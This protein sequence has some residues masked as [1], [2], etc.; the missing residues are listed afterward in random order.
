MSPSYSEARVVQLLEL[1]RKFKDKITSRVEQ[2]HRIWREQDKE[3][4]F[5]ELIFCLLTPQSK[6]KYCWAAVEELFRD[7]FIFHANWRQIAEKL[8]Y[9]RFR[10]TKAKRIE[11]VS[12]NFAEKRTCIVFEILHNCNKNKVARDEL[13]KQINGLGYKEASHFLRNIGRGQELAILDRHIL[14]NLVELGVIEQTPKTL[15]RKK[16]LD[17]EEKMVQFAQAINIPMEHL[18]LLLWAKQTG[19]VFK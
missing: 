19:E 4:M 9:V 3:A 6:A 7:D 10:N 15:T 12:K 17:I 13:V 18:D 2:F 8:N 1:Y 11:R 16:Y 14:K 5:K